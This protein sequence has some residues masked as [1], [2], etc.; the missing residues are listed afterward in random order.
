M[1][2]FNWNRGYCGHAQVASS[3]NCH[4]AVAEI[5]NAHSK[6]WPIFGVV[7]T[8]ACANGNCRELS[9]VWARFVI[10]GQETNAALETRSPSDA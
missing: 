8:I 5:R 6:R 9:L 10:L 3:Q 7:S 4:E 1:K 2:P